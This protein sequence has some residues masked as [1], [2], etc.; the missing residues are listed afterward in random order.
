[1]RATESLA[2]AKKNKKNKKKD[3]RTKKELKTLFLYPL[4][5]TDLLQS[6]R[7]LLN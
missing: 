3:K 7:F 6:S 2:E 5:L 1:M 4:L